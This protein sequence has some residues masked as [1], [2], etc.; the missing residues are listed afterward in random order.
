[1]DKMCIGHPWCITKTT[2]AQND[3]C[4]VGWTA[5]EEISKEESKIGVIHN[6]KTTLYSTKHIACEGMYQF[7]EGECVGNWGRW[8]SATTEGCIFTSSY[9]FNNC[10][11]PHPLVIFLCATK[12]KRL[13]NF[14]VQEDSESQSNNIDYGLRKTNGKASDSWM[15]VVHVVRINT[16]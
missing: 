9:A 6:A 11:P 1:M 2:N 16:I 8:I 4:I 13:I 3:S 15:V 14:Q 5:Q 10:D 7:I 12:S